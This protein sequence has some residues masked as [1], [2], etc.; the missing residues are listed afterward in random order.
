MLDF[1]DGDRMARERRKRVPDLAAMRALKEQQASRRFDVSEAEAAA[2]RADVF[3]SG[4]PEP[5]A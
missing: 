3:G 4:E 2:I 5:V 1:E